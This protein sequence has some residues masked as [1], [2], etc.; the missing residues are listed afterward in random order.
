MLSVIIDNLKTLIDNKV[1]ENTY[2]FD[3]KFTFKERREEFERMNLK[4]PDRVP[5]LVRKSKYN[6][7]PDIDKHKF[8]VPRDLTMGQFI[9]VI[10]K[11]LH[12]PSGSAL[13]VFVGENKIVPNSHSIY[14]VYNKYKSPDGF[15]R[16]IYTEE[17]TFG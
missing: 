17:N 9:F 14:S 10:H 7:A 16:V 13:F 3:E 15:L 12:L 6:Y 1:I 2:D 8:L 4:F 11:R 5:I